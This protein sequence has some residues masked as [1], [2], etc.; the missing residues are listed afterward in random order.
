MGRIGLFCLILT[1]AG[2]AS[3]PRDFE[4]GKEVS[5]LPG[6]I[7]YRKRGGEC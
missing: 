4:T 6:C 7:D 3:P 1:L 5:P 2:C